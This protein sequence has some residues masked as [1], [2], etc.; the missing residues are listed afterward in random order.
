[1]A[2]LLSLGLQ[3]A[4]VLAGDACYQR[5]ALFDDYDRRFDCRLADALVKRPYALTYRVRRTGVVRN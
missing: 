2:E 3:V 5:N 1:M 4:L